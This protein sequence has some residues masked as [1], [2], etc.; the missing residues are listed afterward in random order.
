MNLLLPTKIKRADKRF[1]LPQY[2]TKGSIAFDIYSRVPY[3]LEPNTF[4]R[5]PTNLIIAVPYGV[6]LFVLSRSSTFSKCHCILTNAVGLIDSDYRGNEDEILIELLNLGD[7]PIEIEPGKRIAQGCAMQ[8]YRL[9]WDE[10]DD[11]D[12]VSRGGF[13]STGE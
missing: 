5:L 9:L 8:V 6:G 1:P 11:M 3:I 12:S 2:E 7:A 10:T 13:G 4:V